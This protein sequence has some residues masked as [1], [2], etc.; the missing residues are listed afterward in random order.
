MADLKKIENF[1]SNR[2]VAIVGVSRDPRDFSRTL[3]RELV[4]RQ[5]DVVPVNPLISLIDD[6]HCYG[7]LKDIKPP[8]EAVLIMTPP[9]VSEDIVHQCLDAGVKVVW[10][11]RAA[12]AGA[13]SPNA[14]S[15]CKEHHIDVI[16]GQCPMMFLPDTGFVHRIHRFF[17]K[18]AGNY[19]K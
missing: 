9:S 1:L 13:V 4:S 14:I 10:F 8:V 12:G 16:D 5:Y 19:P 2:R 3:F 15:F 11:Y 18:V 7:D 17:S 6:C